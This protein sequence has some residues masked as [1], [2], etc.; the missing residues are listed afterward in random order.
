[1][2]W[3][4]LALLALVL[5]AVGARSEEAPGGKIV[6]PRKEAEGVFKLHVMNADGTGDQV[7]PGQTSAVNLFPTWSPDGK[8]IA[9]MTSGM[10]NAE[11]HQ[12]CLINADGTGLTTLNVPSQRSG[13][14]AWSPDG[15]QL[16]YSAGDQIPGVYLS[17]TS[18]A[19]ARQLNPPGTGGFGAFWMPDGKRL[20]Y[21]RFEPGKMA[22]RILLVN[23]DGTGEEPVTAEEGLALAGPNALSPDGKKLLYMVLDPQNQKASLRMW[24]FATKGENFVLETSLGDGKESFEKFP[25][26]AW[27]PD[28][29]SYLVSL[30][31]DKGMG[32]FRISDDGKTRTRLT[33]EGVDCLAGAWLPAR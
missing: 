14:A 31:T 28:G 10:L 11:Q 13:L 3:L 23:P 26:P 7:L 27:S 33:P 19:G 25:M 9:F 5:S 21:T 18:G 1:M 24:E 15:R 20:G 4:P 16:A 29:K 6:Y 22:G 17:D 32:L 8:R 12:V 30:T 2:R